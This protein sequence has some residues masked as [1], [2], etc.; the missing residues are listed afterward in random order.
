MRVRYG[1]EYTGFVV[2]CYALEPD[3]SRR[4][5]DSSFLSRPKGT[6][7]SGIAAALCMFEAFGPCRFAGYAKGGETYTFLGQTYAYQPGEPMGKPIHNPMVRIMATEEGQSGNTFDSVYYNLTDEDAPLYALKAAYGI[8]AGKTR[9]L[10]GSGGSIVPSTAGS[11]SKDGGLE[12]FAVFDEALALDT[13]LPTPSGWTRMGDVQ[14]GDVLVGADGCPVTVV[15]TTEI[16]DDRVCFKVTFRNGESVVASDGHL[17]ATRVTG[18]AAKPKIRTTGEMYRDGRKFSVPASHG[19]DT[20]EIDVPIDPYILG[21]WLGDGDKNNATISTSPTDA[22][23]LVAQIEGCGYTATVNAARNLVYVSVPGS[24]RNRFSPVKGLKVRLRDTGLLGRKHIPDLYMRAGTRQR[25]DL[26]RGLMDSDGCC[27]K[28]GHVTFTTNDGTFRDQVAELLRS[29][30]QAPGGG[31]QDDPRS[32]TGV[33]YR[34]WFAPRWGFV[35]FRYARKV[36][37]LRKNPFS[38]WDSI[39]S[40]EAVESVPVRCVGV[41]STDHLFLAGRGWNVTHNTHLYTTDTLRNMYKTVVRNLVKRRRE[42]S[43]F[44]ETTTMYEPGEESIAEDTYFLADQIEEKK[45]RRPRLLFD[46]RWADMASL[47]KIKV[48]DDTLKGGERVETED[49]YITRL[50]NGFVEAFG[51]AIAWND[52]E[53]LLDAMFDTRQSESETLRYFFNCLVAASNAWL[54]LNEWTSIG[55]RARAAKA[56]AEKR[57]LGIKAPRRGDQISLGFDGSLNRD[58]T[59][60]IACRIS[61]GYVFPIGIWEAPDSKEAA[62][63]TVDHQA[64]E[65]TLIDTF[66]KFDVVAF[67]ADPPHWRDYVDRWET[68]F[69]PDL[70]VHNTEAKPITFET[71]Q[72]TQMAKVIERA[73][74][75]IKTG[76]IIH[77]DHLALT[78]HVMNARIWKRPAGHVI[79]K[80]VRNST[81]KMDAA[82]GMALAIEGR[83]RYKKQFKDT[84]AVPTRVR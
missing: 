14:V 81:K 26:I 82:V 58:A 25:E 59:V 27:G 69:G 60:L 33:M 34:L 64:V 55:L 10:I 80:D 73:E 53:G 31:K 56:K 71:S 7:K 17:W 67:L 74:T 28:N 52:P 11:A 19:V 24:H 36:A 3:G 47:E 21:L 12:T 30:G 35:P 45:A 48:K 66:K 75:A 9:V 8:D 63:W 37:R 49:E 23:E 2:D 40:I 43:W 1:D 5:Y 62:H 38:G 20:P 32:R 70:V 44:I 6:D 61:D 68:K 42:G 15:K 72:H 84:T 79:G 78:R 29:V 18:S 4:L 57:P 51:D 83:A 41:D 16:M 46:H 22:D 54:K 50:R 65:A 39:A 13:P 76:D 77:G